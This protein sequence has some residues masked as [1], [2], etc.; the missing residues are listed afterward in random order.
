MDK[1]S[2]IKLLSR[3]RWL[4]RKGILL[5]TVPVIVWITLNQL[6]IKVSERDQHIMRIISPEGMT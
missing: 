3:S 1:K 5:V 2:I 6:K 4:C